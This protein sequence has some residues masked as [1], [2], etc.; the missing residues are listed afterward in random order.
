MES[1]RGGRD[2]NY[3]ILGSVLSKMADVVPFPRKDQD[4]LEFRRGE[5]LIRG[6]NESQLFRAGG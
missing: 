5:I 3:E 1:R 6:V 2:S 4:D